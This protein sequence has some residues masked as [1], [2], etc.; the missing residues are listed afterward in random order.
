M[1]RVWYLVPQTPLQ[2]I[3][4]CMRD[5]HSDVSV[6]VALPVSVLRL[7]CCQGTGGHWLRARGLTAVRCSLAVCCA[8]PCCVQVCPS[9][10]A[11]C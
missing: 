6:W 2:R 11:T 5:I 3:L 9:C 1:S 7:C 8:V 10:M 4:G